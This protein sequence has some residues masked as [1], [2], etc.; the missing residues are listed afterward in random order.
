MQSRDS[1]LKKD[2][3]CAEALASLKSEITTLRRIL[4]CG[5]TTNIERCFEEVEN[6]SSGSNIREDS[7]NGV[8]CR[9]EVNDK[10]GS[11]QIRLEDMHIKYQHD[12]SVNSHFQSDIDITKRLLCDALAKVNQVEKHY[13]EVKYKLESRSLENLDDSKPNDLDAKVEVCDK[14]TMTDEVMDR[15]SEEETYRLLDLGRNNKCVNN[16]EEMVSEIEE[17]R[18]VLNSNERQNE[19]LLILK[20]SID[21]ASTNVDNVL[22]KT[23]IAAMNSDDFLHGIDDHVSENSFDLDIRK[24]SLMRLLGRNKEIED[25]CIKLCIE[26]ENMQKENERVREELKKL[27]QKINDISICKMDNESLDH[28]LTE[29]RDNNDRIKKDIKVDHHEDWINFIAEFTVEQSLTYVTR[30]IELDQ[31][32]SKELSLWKESIA[33]LKN[34]VEDERKEKLKALGMS[35]SNEKR[36]EMIMNELNAT[37]SSWENSKESMKEDKSK[38]KVMTSELEFMEAKVTD[39]KKEMQQKSKEK[40]ELEKLCLELTKNCDIL[41]EKCHMKDEDL[42]KLEGKLKSTNDEIIILKNKVAEQDFIT[43]KLKS[44]TAK[45]TTENSINDGLQTN[46][47]SEDMDHIENDFQK[48]AQEENIDLKKFERSESNVLRLER[49]ATFLIKD[50]E[51]L[52]R[53]N[54]SDSPLVGLDVEDKLENDN[55]RNPNNLRRNTFLINDYEHL[56]RGTQSDSPLVELDGED[57]L[58]NDNKQDPN[59]RKEINKK[60]SELS[61]DKRSSL[62]VILED[63][64]EEQLTICCNKFTKITE[65]DEC[66]EDVLHNAAESIV[67]QS[68]N[69]A[70]RIFRLENYITVIIRSLK[71]ER[72]NSSKKQMQ[73]NE[74]LASNQSLQNENKQLKNGLERVITT[75]N[76]ILEDYCNAIMKMLSSS[77]CNIKLEDID[78]MKKQLLQ[79]ADKCMNDNCSQVI[80]ISPCIGRK[81]LRSQMC[82][83]VNN[84]DSI[85]RMLRRRKER[86]KLRWNKKF[87]TEKTEPSYVKTEKEKENKSEK[88]V[89][90][91]ESCL[92]KM[93]G[94]VAKYISDIAISRALMQMGFESDDVLKY[95]IKRGDNENNNKFDISFEEEVVCKDTM[96]VVTTMNKEDTMDEKQLQMLPILE[97]CDPLLMHEMESLKDLFLRFRSAK[98]IKNFARQMRR[99]SSKSNE[100]KKEEFSLES[101]LH[102]FE[103]G[104]GQIRAPSLTEDCLFFA[105]LVIINFKGY[106][107]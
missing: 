1:S 55:K 46:T 10:D 90:E 53:G 15:G 87:K 62:S 6:F 14:R 12:T 98:L 2:C 16:S 95:Y 49:Q 93:Q 5:P 39:M 107:F 82:S 17:I 7:V 33:K 59:D 84:V 58:K 21:R 70:M 92:S 67:S 8:K 100:I 51:H 80:P 91:A 52:S 32:F 78:D 104:L 56:S 3:C 106:T 27:Q 72:L 94:I 20:E 81:L 45:L 96:L 48:S 22:E 83:T 77:N 9:Q 31:R 13:G 102:N 65:V 44:E 29:N 4:L 11:S 99:H 38:L 105:E 64:S 25:H 50:Y 97:E 88:K 19:A 41:I 61:R 103:E 101:L 85:G 35:E 89:V 26:F 57:K 37:I 63:G 73:I 28:T 23:E 36:I 68:V 76:R 42:K 24:D 47:A 75:S 74:F 43:E 40:E 30:T 34:E 86:E 66:N 71:L 18:G 60:E 79:L 69:E 54:Q